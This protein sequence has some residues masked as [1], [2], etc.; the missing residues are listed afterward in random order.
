VAV[1]ALAGS[2]V[3]ELAHH[4]QVSRKFV[5]QQADRARHALDQVF[6]P[7]PPPTEKVLF[8]LPVTKSWLR[9]FILALVLIGHC[10]LRGVLEILRDLFDWDMALGTIVNV[11]RAAVA[12]ARSHNADQDLSRIHVGAHDEI[13]QNRQPVLVGVD[14]ASTYCYLLSQ[15]EHR[16]GDTWA[17]HLWDLQAQ[18]FAPQA[19]IADGGTGLRAGQKYALP[20]V[21]CRADVFHAER[22]LGQLV[23]YLENRAYGVLAAADR[24]ER[25]ARRSARAGHDPECQRR[26]DGARREAAQAVALADAV[27]LLATWLRDDILAV[28]GPPLEERQALFDFV[29]AEL[30]QRE[31]AAEHRIRPVRRVLENQRDDLLAFVVDLDRDILS[32]AGYGRV[33]PAVIRTM[34]AVQTAPLASAER[35]QRAAVVRRQLGERYEEV[36]A[37]VDVLLADV[38][39]ASSVVENLNSRLRS[40]FF[41]RRELG[42]DYLD[43]L[44]F[45]LNH[46]RFLR[47]SHPE[48]VGHSPAELLSGQEHPHWLELLGYPRFRRAG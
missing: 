40:Y 2:S 5:Y 42:A 32:L 21:P 14:V 44:R 19:L 16:D 27:A 24:L 30:R 12:Q 18:G 43:L 3:S 9:Q 47:S 41:L 7:P 37:W 34:V 29:I 11:V 48:R 26:W 46:R 15:E 8:C 35:W 39:R 17:I 36:S 31:P 10:P 33:S 4:L 22:E 23:H 38:V 25:Q 20:D 28:A 6:T 13:F 1:D 45:F